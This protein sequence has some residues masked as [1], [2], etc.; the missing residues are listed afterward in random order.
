[1]YVVKRS[2][3]NLQY[4]DILLDYNITEIDFKGIISNVDFSEILVTKKIFL[5]KRMLNKVA[6]SRVEFTELPLSRAKIACFSA[7]SFTTLKC[8]NI[9][10][11]K[12]PT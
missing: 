2:N 10:S 12:Y 5:V 11:G 4:P 3:R 8:F 9:T 1:M 6:Q 7:D